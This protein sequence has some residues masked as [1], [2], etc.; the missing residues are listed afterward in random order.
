MPIIGGR[1]VGVRGL[2]F[3]GAG[4]PGVPTINSVTRVSDTQVTLGYTLGASNGAPI[5]SIEIISSPSIT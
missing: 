2:G 4:K 1:Q 5:T 3:Q